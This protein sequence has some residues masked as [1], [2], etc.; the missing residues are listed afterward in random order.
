MKEYLGIRYKRAGASKKGFDCSGFVKV[1]YNK[2]FGIDLPHQSSQQSR[3]KELDDIPRDKLRTGDLIFFSLSKKKKNIN[4]VGIYYSD[5]KFIHSSRNKGIIISPLDDSYWLPRVVKAKRLLSRN[6][7]DSNDIFLDLSMFLTC[8]DAVFL[9][10]EK[11]KFQPFSGPLFRGD[12]DVPYSGH[13]FQNLE[14][15]YEKTISPALTT[16]FNVFRESLLYASRDTTDT[17]ADYPVKPEIDGIYAQGLRISSDFRHSENLSIIPSISYYKY[18]PGVDE[19]NLPMLSM[20]LTYNFYSSSDGWGLS[21]GFRLPLSRYAPSVSEEPNDDIM[22]SMTYHQQIADN[23]QF[24]LSGNNFFD[25]LPG[26]NKSSSLFNREN[27]QF[28]FML[29]FFY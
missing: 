15:G 21:T 29:R 19:E 7:S 24:I 25:I 12:Q 20:D 4:H 27:R 16:Q 28:N 17:S 23:V 26:T 6:N 5:G 3:S 22:I 14:V 13:F 10:Y 1:F 11:I 8:Q 9:R 18:G 2:Y